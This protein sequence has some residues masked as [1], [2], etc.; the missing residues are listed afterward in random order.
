MR[1]I[2]FTA[3]FLTVAESCQSNNFQFQNLN[4]SPIKATTN[5]IHTQPHQP[6]PSYRTM[7]GPSLDND[8]W[9]KDLPPLPEGWNWNRYRFLS[10]AEWEALPED[11]HSS[12]RDYQ[13]ARYSRW[14]QIRGADDVAAERASIL[15]ARRLDLIPSQHGTPGAEGK[16]QRKAARAEEA[17]RDF[18]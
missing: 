11:L 15:Q 7:P 3:W 9:F 10:S 6:P 1:L 4:T 14:R 16:A 18:L 8:A 13:D 2:S 12:L 5:P 17:A